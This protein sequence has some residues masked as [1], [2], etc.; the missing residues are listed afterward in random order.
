VLVSVSVFYSAALTWFKEHFIKC[1]DRAALVKT[2]LPAQYDGPK[3][4]LDQLVYDRALVL[5]SPPLLP[6]LF[7]IDLFSAVVLF[8]PCVVVRV[9]LQHA[10]SCWTRR[11][12]QTS[13]RSC[14]RSRCGVCTRYKTTCCK[15]G[16]LLW[17]KIVQR[18]QPV[19]ISSSIHTL[20]LLIP[21]ALGVG[22][23]R[24][25]LRLLRCRA[26][27]AMN[28]RDRL[29][30]ARADHNLVDVARYPPPW[31]VQPVDQVPPSSR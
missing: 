9:G 29:T 4:W 15:Q 19:R 21:G 30:D 11:R 23:K 24:T 28:D 14:T 2:W 26:R 13:A 27:M 10:R 5:V 25:K 7:I 31:E 17:R 6:R 1:N 8:F 16:T 18:L 20:I 3:S 12:P 22:I